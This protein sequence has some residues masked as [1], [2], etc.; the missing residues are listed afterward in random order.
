MD[1]L[2]RASAS[3]Q[4]APAPPH[5]ETFQHKLEQF[6]PGMVWL[7]ADGH[8]TAFNDVAM[9][10]LGPAAEQSLGVAPDALLGIDVLQLH[11]EKSRDK[12]R[13]LLHSQDAGGCPV[14][15][16]PPLAMMIN[17]PDRI[18][19]IKVSKMSNRNGVCGTCMIFYDVTDIT[20]EPA[21][22]TPEA[23]HQ[24]P[25]RLFKIPVYRRN[26]VILIDLKDIVRFQGDGHYTTIV[27]RDDRYLSNLSLA[28]LELRLDSSI[29][30]RVHRSHIVSLPHAVE[31]AK[32]DEGV[33][34][35]MGDEERTTVPVSR[36]R[37]A[38][39]KELLGV[40]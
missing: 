17:I 32:T 19:M 36:A 38:Q 7:D 9:Q 16:P 35:V 25:R 5:H 20:T 37:A 21:Q 8:V 40:V 34:L 31:L 4:P 1:P 12:L 27:T 28:D 13:F 2:E 22:R 26:R 39:L 14:K 18:L 33:S 3:A 11:P 24:A 23:Q 6:N 29:Y 15:S 30:L 10:I